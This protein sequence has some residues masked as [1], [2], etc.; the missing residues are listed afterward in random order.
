MSSPCGTNPCSGFGVCRQV[1]PARWCIRR[2]WLRA[3]VT[4]EISAAPFVSRPCLQSPSAFS[5]CRHRDEALRAVLLQPSRCASLT[6]N[7]QS[8][9]GMRAFPWRVCLHCSKRFRT[10]SISGMRDLLLRAIAFLPAGSTGGSMTLTF[11]PIRFHAGLPQ[12]H[13]GHECNRD[14]QT[15][16]G[17]NCT[18]FSPSGRVALNTALDPRFPLQ[19]AK[20]SG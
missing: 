2:L 7:D 8:S 17:R 4:P 10:S 19:R 9:S 15:I 18:W 1:L 6:A 5:A 16:E 11:I 12:A 14:G 13:S 20:K 3:R